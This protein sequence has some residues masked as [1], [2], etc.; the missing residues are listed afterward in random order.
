MRRGFVAVMALALVSWPSAA[1]GD[2]VRVVDRGGTV[3][4]VSDAYTVAIAPGLSLAPA[5][6]TFGSTAPSSANCRG[7][8]QGRQVT[9]LG[10]VSIKDGVMSGSTCARA[11]GKA[12]A[13]FTVP[14]ADGP[15]EFVNHFTFESAG[16]GGTFT[17]D[18]ASGVFAFTPTK[19]DC[20]S[21]PLTSVTVHR[22][23]GR[24]VLVPTA[25]DGPGLALVAS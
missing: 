22:L 4:C 15:V 8:V 6:Q 17:G 21:E 3:V 20:V 23:G 10:T 14:T 25:D 5:E 12:R 18:L 2:E 7:S 1:V 16:A 11:S 24:I 13:V 9:G 19:G